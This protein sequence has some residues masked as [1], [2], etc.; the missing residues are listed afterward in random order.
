[1]MVKEN[2]NFDENEDRFQSICRNLQINDLL[3][4]L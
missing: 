2:L 1:M 3:N 4:T